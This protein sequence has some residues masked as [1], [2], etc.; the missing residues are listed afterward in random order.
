MRSY[1]A[2]DSTDKWKSYNP[3]L[4]NWVVHDLTEISRE[5]GYWVYSSNITE[6]YKLGELLSPSFIDLES[7]WNMIGYPMLS[8]RE[9]NQTFGGLIP[10]FDYVL[11]YNSSDISDPW[12]EWTWNSSLSGDLAIGYIC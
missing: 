12:K 7:G 4:P 2:G 3:D 11:A 10:T 9:I 5:K 6:F 8:D 1:D